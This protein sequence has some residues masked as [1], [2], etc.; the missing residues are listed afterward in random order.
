VVTVAGAVGLASADAA[1]ELVTN[2]VHKFFPRSFLKLKLLSAFI[3]S[4][5]FNFRCFVD[6]VS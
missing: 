5:A 2:I 1:L 4:H 3:F 6:L